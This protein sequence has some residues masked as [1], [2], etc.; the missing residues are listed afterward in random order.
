MGRH[1]FYLSPIPVLVHRVSLIGETGDLLL[2]GMYR[3][4]WMYASVQDLKLIAMRLR[5]HRRRF[6]Q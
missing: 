5:W 6:L 4:L 2:F 3:R 1:L